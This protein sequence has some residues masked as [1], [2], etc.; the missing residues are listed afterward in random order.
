MLAAPAWSLD[1]QASVPLILL[2][3]AFS[4]D[5]EST[6][7]KS[8]IEYGIEADCELYHSGLPLSWKLFALN[9]SKN[10]LNSLTAFQSEHGS[11]LGPFNSF[12]SGRFHRNQIGRR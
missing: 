9:L 6:L 8:K 7:K 2:V 10:F 12:L 1:W 3:T 11:V 4:R 5:I